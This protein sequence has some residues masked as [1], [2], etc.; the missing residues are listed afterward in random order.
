MR[1]GSIYSLNDPDTGVVRYVGQTIIKVESRY[2]QHIYQW[3]RSLGRLTHINSWIKSLYDRGKKPVLKV[4]EE[5]ISLC[6]LD[7]KEIHYIQIFKDKGFDL[8]NHSLGGGGTRGIKRTKETQEKIT[9]A[10]NNS[11]A[12]KE[13]HKRH[14]IIMKQKHA[15][16]KL[17]FGYQNLPAEQRKEIGANH[18]KTMK[19]LHKEGKINMDK[20]LESVRKPV[21]WLDVL[22]NIECIY[23]SGSEAAR[24]LGI[25]HSSGISEVC[26]GKREKTYGMRF[27][28]V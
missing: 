14:S 26:K 3:K 8:C 23:V 10:L 6:D 9:K 28:Y 2:A 20:C 4:I 19:R 21:A 11:E 13:K 22:G 7:N 17:K 1:T 18:S 16:G 24:Q 15:E 25:A 12:W 5:G 27:K